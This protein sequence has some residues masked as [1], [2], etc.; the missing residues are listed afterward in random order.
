MN[1]ASTLPTWGNIKNFLNVSFFQI[2]K[3]FLLVSLK[4]IL[5]LASNLFINS[6][7][8]K[9]TKDC[10]VYRINTEYTHIFVCEIYDK[11]FRGKKTLI[12]KLFKTHGL[13]DS[14]EGGKGDIYTL[15]YKFFIFMQHVWHWRLLYK[16][17]FLI[18]QRRSAN[19][20]SDTS[21]SMFHF[22]SF[23]R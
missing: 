23:S 11:W 17:N 21:G 15:S 12:C 1:Q 9:Y 14:D 16:I 7:L 5:F 2:K 20:T 4:V 8:I 10:I 22:S 6:S 3:N 18:V 13:K 19:K